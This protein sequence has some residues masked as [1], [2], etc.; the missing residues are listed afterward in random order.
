MSQSWVVRR[1]R[2][3][4]VNAV[5]V[6][7]ETLFSAPHWTWTMYAAMVDAPAEDAVKRGLFV[8]EETGSM[9]GF[10]AGKVLDG[11]AELESIAVEANAQRRGV[12]RSLCEAV[13]QWS[14]AEGSR[15]MELEV[16]VGSVGA[17]RLYEGLGFLRTGR[18]AGYY[19]NPVEDA[20]VMRKEMG[21]Q[22]GE[23][24]ILRVRT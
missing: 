14:C 10:A 7:E 12:G 1:A 17:V 3:A 20:L 18:R 21:G 13:M 2:K 16:R 8:A 5:V 24:E 19:S 15:V 11:E 22:G 6:L 23:G 4:D 9:I